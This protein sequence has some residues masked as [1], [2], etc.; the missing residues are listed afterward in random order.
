MQT[1][2]S[3]G[4]G[5]S[6]ASYDLDIRGAGNLLGD[7]QSGHVREVGVEL[8]QEMLKEAVAAAKLGDG[9]ASVEDT[10]WSPVINMG[11][12]VLIP[13]N[14]VEDL[15]VRL[16][17]YRRIASMESTEDLDQLTAELVDRFGAIPE[18]VKNLLD[19]IS[20]KILCRMTNIA[21]VDAGPKGVSLQFRN[22]TFANPERLIA[23]IASKNGLYQLTGDHRL[24]MKQT[25]PQ[26]SRA[27]VVK[28]ALEELVGLMA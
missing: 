2:D 11:A 18:E 27:K 20:I 8:Y 6:L 26:S 19:T 3:L 24:V 21:K 7:E 15:T 4:A 14:Y 28:R 10:Q 5:F 9:E 23:H 13:D 25:L 17:L 12:A 22:N 16:S 1:L